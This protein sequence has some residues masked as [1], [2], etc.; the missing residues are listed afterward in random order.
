MEL[1]FF[2]A[3]GLGLIGEAYSCCLSKTRFQK[4]GF[5]LA[6]GLDSEGI[7]LRNYF[8]LTPNENNQVPQSRET[9]TSFVRFAC[10][11]SFK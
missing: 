4:R 11:R 1:I 10:V 5:S 3:N 6:S 7:T 9:F 8:Q 2:G